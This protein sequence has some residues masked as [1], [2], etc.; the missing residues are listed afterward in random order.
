MP[1]SLVLRRPD[2]WH[3]HL[4]DGAHLAG[5][6]GATAR[7]F[8]RALVMPN[9]KPPVTTTAAALA[10]RERILA[11]LPRGCEFS[12][13]MTL[14]L[15]DTTTPEEIVRAQASG[16]IKAVKYYPAG[17]TTNSAS[18]VTDVELAFPA[19]AAMEAHG[20]VL[21]VHG[22]VTDPDVDAFDRE[23]VFVDRVLAAI[24]RRFPALR[25][26]L[27]HVTTADAVQF[28]TSAGPHVAA[29]LTPQHLL[30]SRNAL[31]AGG[32]RPHLYCLPILKRERHRQA[33]V[34]A[35]VSGSPQFFLG[36][37]SAP[38][39]RGAK[40]QAC[41]CAGC[42]TAH[43]ALELYAEVFE[44]AG[45]LHRLDDF[46]GGFGADFYGVPRNATTVTLAR[47]PWRVPDEYPFGEDTVVPLRSGE[48]LR[49][50]V[51]G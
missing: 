38:H 37:D 13:L 27:E 39:A 11:A 12:P 14:Y 21:S 2:D 1:T 45:A 15:T 25:I 5:V 26:V 50:K 18:G 48:S 36:T 8:A 6:V 32:L 17:A 40:E 30:Y 4:R 42:Y 3:L 24:V 23:R 44:D 47:E 33:L 35:A 20:M 46:A 29:T 9:L 51:L 19:L 34:R 43:A 16:V 49:W 41:G 22:E 7:V 28:V 31:F 10:Y